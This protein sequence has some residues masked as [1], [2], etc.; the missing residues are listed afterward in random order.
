MS[1]RIVDTSFQSNLSPVWYCRLSRVLSC[2]QVEEGP[3]HSEVDEFDG[4]RDEEPASNPSRKLRSRRVFKRQGTPLQ[5]LS[6]KQK[7]RGSLYGLIP[8]R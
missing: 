1:V 6:K 7:R 8:I 5:A 3:R 2:L 4:A